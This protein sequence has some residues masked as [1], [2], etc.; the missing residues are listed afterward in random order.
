M[1]HR[2]IGLLLLIALMTLGCQ[3]KRLYDRAEGE[4]YARKRIQ[5]VLMDTTY[6]PSNSQENLVS[7]SELAIAIVE[8]ILFVTYGQ[9]QILNEKPYQAFKVDNYWLIRGS[10]PD[11]P[12]FR[13]GA[14]EII[15]DSRNA[16]VVRMV[17][18]K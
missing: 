10:V 14:F 17:H 12:D 13:G 3:R 1:K 5:Q 2:F 15:I 16:R 4:A 8:P 7:T 6:S 18:Y 11:D 9:K